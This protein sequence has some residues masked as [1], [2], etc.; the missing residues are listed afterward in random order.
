MTGRL[1][2]ASL[3]LLCVLFAS[4][5]SSSQPAAAH[6][7]RNPATVAFTLGTRHAL[8][9]FEQSGVLTVLGLLASN[10]PRGLAITELLDASKLCR[11][12]TYAALRTCIRQGLVEATAD[13][14]SRPAVKLYHLTLLGRRAGALILDFASEIGVSPSE[15]RTQI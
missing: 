11:A 10:Q 13:P 9:V 12:T 2:T 4:S 6:V 15:K 5:I 3:L 8:R 7:A 1:R 14:N